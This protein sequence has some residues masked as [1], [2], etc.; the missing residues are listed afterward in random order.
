MGIGSGDLD[1]YG[2]PVS[3][4]VHHHPTYEPKTITTGRYYLGEWE[5]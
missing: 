4:A 2:F 1:Y 5:V 3:S